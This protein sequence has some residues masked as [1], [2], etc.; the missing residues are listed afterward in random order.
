MKLKPCPF[1]GGKAEIIYSDYKINDVRIQ[2]IKCN[3]KTS[4]WMGEMEELIEQWNT[5]V[6]E[7]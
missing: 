1:C 7:S 4:W 6:K 3:V 5:R 2:C